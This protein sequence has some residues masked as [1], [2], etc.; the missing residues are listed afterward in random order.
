MRNSIIDIIA[1]QNDITHVFIL[2]FNIDFIFIQTVLIPALRWCGYP[3]LTIFADAQQVMN[4]F[5]EQKDWVDGVGIRYRVIPVDMGNHFAFHPKAV[6]LSGEKTGRLLVGSGNLTHGGWVENAEIWVQYESEDDGC[7]PFLLIRD[8]ISK[9][10]TFSCNSIRISHE[11]LD[12]FN[13]DMHEWITP[14]PDNSSNLVTRFNDTFSIYSQ[15][16]EILKNEKIDRLVICS[17]YYD[18]NGSMVLN[19]KNRLNIGRVDVFFDSNG[20][21]LTKKAA[22]NLQKNGVTLKPIRFE[23][24]EGHGAF[25]HAKFYAFFMQSGVHVFSG[26]ANCSIAALDIDVSGRGNAELLNYSFMR[27]SEFAEQFL[28]EIL[29]IDDPVAEYYQAPEHDEKPDE[30]EKFISITNARLDENG[31]TVF[32]KKSDGLEIVKCVVDSVEQSFVNKTTDEIVVQKQISPKRVYLKASDT[33]NEIIS[34][35]SWVDNEFELGDTAKRRSLASIISSGVTQSSWGVNVWIELL[36]KFRENLVYTPSW[37]KVHVEKRD[38]RE[39]TVIVYSRDDIFHNYQSLPARLHV[40][41]TDNPNNKVLTLQQILLQW[42]G[43]GW[44]DEAEVETSDDETA[45][46]EQDI[47]DRAKKELSKTETRKRDTVSSNITKNSIRKKLIAIADAFDRKEFF[48]S[49]PPDLLKID[50]A[51][52]SVILRTGLHE[53]WI[54]VSDFIQLTHRIWCSIFFNG[55]NDAG[56]SYP[57]GW[58]EFMYVN[59]TK[60]EEYMNNLCDIELSASLILW[61]LALDETI[62]SPEDALFNLLCVA[63]IARFPQLWSIEQPERLTNVIVKHLQVTNELNTDDYDMQWMKISKRWNKYL[64]RGAALAQLQNIISKYNL[65]YLK[66]LVQTDL[67]YSGELLWQPSRLGFCVTNANCKRANGYKVEVVS[68]HNPRTI[69]KISAPYLVP[70][71]G[72]L[73]NYDA[74]SPL[75]GLD[76]ESRIIL[77]DYVKELTGRLM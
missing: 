22:E 52:S 77:N 40:P 18:E 50:I 33:L 12:A 29:I 74:S 70:I 49:R 56:L 72:L 51:F 44:K 31:L 10:I 4:S 16:S 34:N 47:I 24:S 23:R 48:T 19:L 28:N 66:E 76:I 75:S 43:Y 5:N 63:S 13:P 71:R 8:Y 53:N 26:S 3:S 15:I 58:L 37:K 1:E 65:D 59:A 41:R 17:P 61:A 67:V 27:K 7:G 60:P 64:A 30:N 69:K 42:F 68:L 38:N 36:D 20:H 6:L 39:N 45:G 9:I 21:T 35:T 11:L 54:D 46:D 32:F 55:S 57:S 14:A 62:D 25:I 2:T 73:D